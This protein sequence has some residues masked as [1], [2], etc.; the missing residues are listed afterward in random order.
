MADLKRTDIAVL[1]A[2]LRD[3]MAPWHIAEA[4]KS[5]LMPTGLIR[6][7]PGSMRCRIVITRAGKDALLAAT[8]PETKP[9]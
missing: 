9:S 5:R 6:W 8:N 3:S 1:R 2:L 4:V 7:K